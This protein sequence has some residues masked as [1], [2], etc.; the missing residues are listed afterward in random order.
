LVLSGLGMITLLCGSFFLPS[1][2]WT[3]AKSNEKST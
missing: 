3:C 1:Y 2:Y